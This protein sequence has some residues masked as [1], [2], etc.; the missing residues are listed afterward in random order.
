MHHD[1]VNS[2]AAARASASTAA[3]SE[4]EREIANEWIYIVTNQLSE[5][6]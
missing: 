3:A 5:S 2:Y 1:D 4:L 6:I